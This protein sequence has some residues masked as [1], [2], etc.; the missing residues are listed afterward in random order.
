MR[1]TLKLGLYDRGLLL[2]VLAVFVFVVLLLSFFVPAI[3][4]ILIFNAIFLFSIFFYLMLFL[5]KHDLGK[6]RAPKNFPSITVII[7]CFNSKSTILDCI[8]SVKRMKYKKKV[9]ILVVDDCSTDGSREIL[10]KI[11]GI[12]LLKL[13]KNCGKSIAVNTAL[14]KVKTEFVICIDSDSF[15]ESDVLMK[16]MGYFEDASIASV[17]CLVLSNKRD[18]LLRKIQNLEYAI[19]FG[20]ANTLLSSINSSYAV[21]GPFTIFR[22][23]VFDIVGYYESGN[24]AE[25]MEFGLRM[26]SYSMR[27]VNC[28]EAVVYTDVPGTLRGLF[29]QRNRWYRGGTFNF[30]RYKKLLFNK[31]NPDFGFFVMPFLFATQVLIVAVLLRMVL[32]FAND[33]YTFVSIFSQYISLGGFF[34]IPLINIFIPP[35]MLFFLASYV[36]I[37]IYFAIC[38][39]EANYKLKW[40]DILPLLVLILIY[41]YF[42][43]FTYSQGYLKEVFGVGEKWRRVS[44]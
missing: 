39:T 35:T 30:I 2:F 37:A 28:H 18:N 43:S 29:I 8:N 12:E 33:I 4:L 17:S 38:F 5:N 7:P 36:L 32:F 10:E 34:S 1:E 11:K 21:P 41:P 40:S 19:G 15:P 31:K 3:Y 14:K 23:K 24:L 26:K 25:D 27:I 44:M 13:E 9:N 20:L 16:T 22:K 6:A 42:I